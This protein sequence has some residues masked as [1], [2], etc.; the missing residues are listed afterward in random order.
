MI[1]IFFFLGGMIALGLQ[2]VLSN[3][4][5]DG[6]LVVEISLILVIYAGFKLNP[7]N[8][9]IFS[10]TLGFF[11]DCLMSSVSGLYALLYLIIFMMANL[12]STRIYGEKKLFIVVFAGLCAFTEGSLV[13]IFYKLIY[14]LDKFH[15][16]GDVLL[17][18][19]IIAGLLA[20][21]FFSLFRRFGDLPACRNYTPV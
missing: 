16:L 4:L 3:L 10:F 15:H 5:F 6:N 18:Q 21:A 7:V 2:T 1:N 12:V 19:A 8:G 14:G 20:P 11:M 17:P 13:M 9:G